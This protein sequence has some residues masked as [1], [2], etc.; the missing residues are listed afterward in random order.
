MRSIASGSAAS[1]DA[2]VKAMS[3]GSFTARMNRRSGTRKTSAIGTKHAEH[4]DDQ[5]AVQRA[6]EHAE[7]CAARRARS[8]R[9]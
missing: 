3:H 7:T 2:V 8:S 5:R 9:P 4:E 6:D 1:D